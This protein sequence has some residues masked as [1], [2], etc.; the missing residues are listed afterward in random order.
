MSRA[1]WTGRG[2]RNGKEMQDSIYG[3]CF[4]QE[5]G[6]VL[7]KLKIHGENVRTGMIYSK[8]KGYAGKNFAAGKEVYKNCGEVVNEN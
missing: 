5:N 8:V 6:A 1:V 7:V 4:F 2:C 3:L